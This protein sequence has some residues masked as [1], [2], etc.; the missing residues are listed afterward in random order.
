MPIVAPQIAE[1]AQLIADPGRANILSSLMNGCSLTAGELA[2]VAGVTPQTA[3][4]HLSKMVSR[5]LLTVEKHGSR[6]FYRLAGP[7]VAQMLESIMTVAVTGPQRIRR[8]LK[9]DEDMRRAR[10]CYDHLAG[11]LGVAIT[12]A[13]VEKGH[14]LLHRDAGQLTTSGITLLG[15]LGVDLSPTFRR[16][17]CR[18]CLDWSEG[19]SHLAGHVGAAIADL[20]FGRG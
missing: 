19:R 11:Q 8:P 14:L 3:S 20:A 15:T 6:R 18:P 17:F 9:I 10:T 7:R 1:V 5:A 4:S 12:D 16:S 2:E 13:L